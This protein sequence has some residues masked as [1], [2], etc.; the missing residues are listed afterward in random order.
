MSARSLPAKGAIYAIG[1]IGG[2]A[3][4]RL[5]G[6]VAYS[7][8]S[9]WFGDGDWT[10]VLGVGFGVLGMVLGLVAAHDFAKRPSSVENS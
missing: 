2:L 9:V 10:L 5:A 7:I 6:S 1:W 8:L 3:G 4:G